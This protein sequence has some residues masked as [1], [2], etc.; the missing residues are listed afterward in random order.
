M[1]LE[2]QQARTNRFVDT[3]KKLLR[4]DSQQVESPV[5]ER[6]HISPDQDEYDQV[7]AD[8]L[9]KLPNVSGYFN[10]LGEQGPSNYYET[11][12]WAVF[13]SPKEP[14]TEMQGDLQSPNR[15]LSAVQTPTSHKPSETSTAVVD[16]SPKRQMSSRRGAFSALASPES[17][18]WRKDIFRRR[19]RRLSK[20]AFGKQP[21]VTAESVQLQTNV[22][23]AKIT[24]PERWRPTTLPMTFDARKPKYDGTAAPSPSSHCSP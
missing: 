9:L 17:P 4:K 12:R 2:Q 7:A 21:K 16:V 6:R 1:I 18:S 23:P 14:D 3:L 24:G 20:N 11:D 5:Q 8:G 10:R 15:R 13:Q 19:P 22:C